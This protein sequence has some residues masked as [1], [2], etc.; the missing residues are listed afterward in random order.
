[1]ALEWNEDMKVCIHHLVCGIRPKSEIKAK[2]VLR[3]NIN[4]KHVYYYI[5]SCY[6]YIYATDMRIITNFYN[7]TKVK[8]IPTSSVMVS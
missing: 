8:Q 2:V 1:M 7:R 6:Y 5:R 3:R 4:Q